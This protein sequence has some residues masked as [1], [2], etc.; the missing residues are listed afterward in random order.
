MWLGDYSKEDNGDV[1]TDTASCRP[2]VTCHAL[3]TENKSIQTNNPLYYCQA[4]T[5]VS[6]GVSLLMYKKHDWE[7]VD[8]T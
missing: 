4:L 5:L 7:V 8:I 6:E 2:L 1:G 3:A